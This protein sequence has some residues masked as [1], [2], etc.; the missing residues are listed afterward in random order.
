M[1][2]LAVAI[3]G[4]VGGLARALLDHHLRPADPAGF[5]RGILTCNLLGSFLLGLVTGWFGGDLR[6]SLLGTGFCGALTTWS[7]FALD[8]VR[9]AQAG[10]LG[11]AAAYVVVSLVTGLAAAY[12]GLAL[13]A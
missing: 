7:T 13:S 9:L 1:I 3:G 11:R 12:A 2:W 4:A 5:P 6:S 8:A 10:R